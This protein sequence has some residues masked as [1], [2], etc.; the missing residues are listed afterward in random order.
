MKNSQT[1]KRATSIGFAA[2]LA[3]F[4]AGCSSAGGANPMTSFT[5]SESKTETPGLFTIAQDQMSHVQV[6]TVQVSKLTDS[7]RSIW[8]SFH[9]IARKRDGFIMAAVCEVK[10]GQFAR[11]IRTDFGLMGL[12]DTTITLRYGHYDAC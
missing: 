7:R 2:M 9:N 5:S 10:K 12:K 8:K 6:V 3:I 11:R 4:L 1:T